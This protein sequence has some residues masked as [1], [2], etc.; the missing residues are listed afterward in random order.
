M[1]MAGFFNNRFISF[2][3]R[4]IVYAS[5]GDA[6]KVGG[7]IFYSNS[8]RGFGSND[9]FWYFG[10]CKT[11]SEEHKRKRINNST[12]VSGNNGYVSPDEQ[13]VSINNRNVSNIR[14]PDNYWRQPQVIVP[15]APIVPPVIRPYR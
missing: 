10:T 14:A 13:A 9:C 7:V 2:H 6:G 3:Y 11:N 4:T 8:Y 1:G 5:G 12:D 15:P